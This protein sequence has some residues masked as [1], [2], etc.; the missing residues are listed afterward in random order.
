MTFYQ[1]TFLFA[2]FFFVA[3]VCPYRQFDD[4]SV[5]YGLLTESKLAKCF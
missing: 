2:L 3:N 4:G 5:L 1:S